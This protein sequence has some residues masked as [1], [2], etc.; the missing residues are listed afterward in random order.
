MIFAAV[1]LQEAHGVKRA[2]DIRALI[3]AR[4]EH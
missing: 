4:L 1:I 3:E 2:K